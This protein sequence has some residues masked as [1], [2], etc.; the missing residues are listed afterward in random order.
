MEIGNDVWIGYGATILSGVRIGDGAIV[1]ANAVVTKDVPPYAI[2]AGN[3]AHVIRMRF[4][5]QI[6]SDL[7]QIQ[8]WNWPF[9]K[10]RKNMPL[11]LSDNITK[12]I[13]QAQA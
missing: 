3:P 7:L 1:G 11:L 9:D 2:V 6:I 8:W 13:Q 12:F 4:S 10:I 5:P